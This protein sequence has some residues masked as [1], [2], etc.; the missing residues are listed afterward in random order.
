MINVKEEMV[1]IIWKKKKLFQWDI[2]KVQL[3]NKISL[4]VDGFKLKIILLKGGEIYF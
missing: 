4:S 2:K 1:W 3:R